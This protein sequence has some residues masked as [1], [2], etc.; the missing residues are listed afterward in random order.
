MPSNARQSFDSNVKDIDRLLGFHTHKGGDA[1]GRRY[2]L[3]VLNKS[4]IVLTTS[5]WE[6]Y[7]EDLAAEA[8]G[9]LVKYA[10]SASA[11]PKELK[12]RIAKELKD[13]KNEIAIWDISDHGWKNVL[14]ARLTAM[15]EERN[16]RLNTPKTSQIDELFNSAIGI[17]KVSSSWHWPKKMTVVR[18]R[19]KLDKYVTLRG[20]IAHRGTAAA[21]VK[22]HDVTD[23]F[24]FIKRLASKTGGAVSA[25]V[26]STTGKPLW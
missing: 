2:G 24:G 20:A 11:L 14:S 25:N 22:K 15:Q 6:A 1:K 19:A 26:K 4:A 8:L 23:Y 17:L 13:D 16:R 3:E 21:S 7:C 12:K 9:H 18:A 10:A 5:F